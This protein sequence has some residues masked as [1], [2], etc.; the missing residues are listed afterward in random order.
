[1]LRWRYRAPFSYMPVVEVGKG[2]DYSGAVAIEAVFPD[3]RKGKHPLVGDAK[4]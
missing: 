2:S 3:V 4:S 1:M